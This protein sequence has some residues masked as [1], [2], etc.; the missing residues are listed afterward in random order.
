MPLRHP[1]RLQG[2]DGNNVGKITHA[3]YPTL[4]IQGQKQ[5]LTPMMITNMGDY[6]LILGLPW[7]EHH[8]VLIDPTQRRITFSQPT[9]KIKETKT[10][11]KPTGTPK[12]AV[13]PRIQILKRQPLTAVEEDPVV[14]NVETISQ[15]RPAKSSTCQALPSIAKPAM[16][17][18]VRPAKSNTDGTGHTFG[19][20]VS[21]NA[22][23]VDYSLPTPPD[24]TGP[25]P[26]PNPLTVDIKMIGAVPF[27]R[28]LRK[29]GASEVFS[30]SL[31]EI[32]EE[33]GGEPKEEIDYRKILPAEYH[34]LIDV[35]S[36]KAS[37]ELPPHRPYDHKIELEGEHKPGHA[38]LYKMSQ[39]ELVAVKKYLEE[40]LAKGFIEASSAPYAAPILFVRKKDGSL[41][42]CVDYRRLNGITKKN[43]YPLPLIE[44]T[45]AR[46]TKA[47]IYSKIDIR[48]AFHRIRM[49]SDSEDLTTFRTRHGSYKYKVLPFGLTGGP[50]T[51]QH[52][53]NDVLFDLLD[54]CCT[55]Y[56]DDILIYSDSL[57]EHRMHVRAVLERLRKAG[58]QVDL[59]KCEF[60]VTET[61]YLGMIVSTKGIRVD[62]DKIA[63]VIAWQVPQNLKQLQAFLGFCNFYRRF[64]RNYSRIAKPLTDLTRKE[65]PFD[66]HKPPYLTAFQELKDRLANAPVL[67][68]FDPT[69]ECYVECDASDYVTAGVLSQK[70]GDGQLHPIAY[71]SKKMAPAECNYEIY[72]KE[73]L[74]I[75]RCLEEWR[76]ELEGTDLPVQILTDH[77]ALEYFMTTKKLTRRQVRWAEFL[78]RYNF[79]ITYRTG[80]ANEKADALTR[81]PG[82]RPTTAEDDERL[83]Y[84]EQILLPPER[85][86]SETVQTVYDDP[87]LEVEESLN[88]LIDQKT[89]ED[90][91]CQ[92]ILQALRE[93]Q[94]KST[95]I[96][97]ADCTNENDRLK[98]RG[99]IWIPGND[100]KEESCKLRL[101][102]IREAHEV[103]AAGHPGIAKTLELLSRDYYWP[104]MDKT[105]ARFIKNC[106][107]CRRSKTPKDK[108]QGALKPL[109]IP[110]RPW[111]DITLDF[112]TGLP[113]CNGFN[114][115]LVVV[116]R[117]TKQRHFIPCS[118]DSE[119]GISAEVVAR[120]LLQHVWRLHG[121]P[122]SITSDRG[123]QFISQLWK[124]LC[125]IL[126]INARLSTAGHPE[127][128]GQTENANAGMEQYLRMYVNYQQDD[129]V[130]WLPMAE[131]AINNAVSESTKVSPFFAN[132]GFHPRMSFS[133]PA[134]TVST[135]TREK[136]LQGKATEIGIHM[137]DL[138]EELRANLTLAQHR[139]EAFADQ[140]RSIAPAYRIG[141]KVW[142]MTKNL[143]SKRPSRKL[144]HKMEGPFEVK[145]IISAQ[146][147]KLDLPLSMKI[148]PVFHTSLLRPAS[149]DPLPGQIEPP[150]P[151][152]ITEWE[153]PEWELEEVEDSRWYRRRLQYRVKWMGF[154]PDRTWYNADGFENAQELVKMFH[155]RYPKK[156][157]PRQLAGAR[158]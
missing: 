13:V 109:P 111:A 147:Y 31:R 138:L 45:L 40:N 36:K 103:P 112:V 61:K 146:A 101:R 47:R 63:A 30:L 114:S 10:F 89:R 70:D 133:D 119:G 82:D 100:D 76:P 96:T 69:R 151:P 95:K 58:L 154:P 34:D 144:D 83:R 52:Y 78:S 29:E 91:F 42:F 110:E 129:W 130:G 55:A 5:R 139:Q 35:F 157:G 53:I 121:L 62:P 90:E 28:S 65:I 59:K 43:R 88:D 49:D 125:R 72:D 116:D 54:V 134:P 8:G 24:T 20:R 60:H 97:L 11:P 23:P 50:S 19:R 25:E 123:S 68:H 141:D 15:V 16:I 74:A 14:I 87:D 106:H 46:L 56:L 39:E 44:E 142:L 152:V 148:H 27:I 81:R 1:R 128:D 75:I 21:T 2:F 7:M 104:R 37:D 153:E 64:I 150:P 115:I 86:S 93:G 32:N 12:K 92:E 57:G 3:I 117:L 118:T 120:L 126:R 22:A 26:D 113:E 131:F 84:Q 105:I 132:H 41:R 71:F 140:R 158:R 33:M 136:I 127:T 135:S 66:M 38:P 156:P 98:Y 108:Y 6:P 73:L 143:R 80:K 18:Q 51:F 94:T 122:S 107:I 79:T 48:Q 4:H 67:S 102:L 99:K 149:D 9:E 85:F 137:K 124:H 17:S 155:K 145:K 77:K